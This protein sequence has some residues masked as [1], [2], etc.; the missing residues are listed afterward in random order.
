MGLSD[1]HEAG[2]SLTIGIDYKKE[3]LASK[4]SDDKEFDNINN[5]FEIKL[6]TVLRDKNEQFLP[7][8]S[9]LNRKSS[10]L[11]GSIDSSINQYFYKL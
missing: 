10:N 1:T 3:K 11:F 4:T 9:T 6:A 7:K 8:S 5:Y 2:K